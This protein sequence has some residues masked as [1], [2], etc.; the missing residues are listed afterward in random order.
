MKLAVLLFAPLLAAA[1]QSAGTPSEDLAHV[2]SEGNPERR[3]RA[4]LDNA[5]EAVRSAH[6][7]Y[8]KGD[9]ASTSAR[10]EEVEQSVEL[11]DSALKQTG[12]NPSRNPK[13]FKQ[14]ELKSR[15][16]LRRLDA[17]REEMS[18]A[19]R[20]TMDRVIGTVQRT[21]DAWLDGIMG[22]KK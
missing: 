17:F 5:E 13:Y 9:V 7:S 16:L 11:A 18:V 8:V 2:Q 19:D 6:E 21:H 4:A 22:K 14:A 10:L 15:G 20:E 1:G 12:K 3:S